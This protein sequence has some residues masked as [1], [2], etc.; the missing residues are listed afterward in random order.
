MGALTTFDPNA[1]DNV[2]AGAATGAT[3]PKRRARRR[4][5]LVGAYIALVLFM[6]IY[7]GRPEDWIPGLASV[8]LAKIAGVLALVGL[9]FSFQHIRKRFPR[10]FTY[11]LLLIAQLFL[12]SIFSHIWRGGAV[13]NTLDFAKVLLVFLILI[14]AVNTMRRL[15]VLIFV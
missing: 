3:P 15:R 10:E 4:M 14:T 8:P 7:Y 6:V 13:M 12:A 11:L 5:P 1:P 2:V 9:V